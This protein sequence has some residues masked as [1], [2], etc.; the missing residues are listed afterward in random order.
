MGSNQDPKTIPNLINGLVDADPWVILTLTAEPETINNGDTSTITVDFNHINDGSA[1][2]GGHIPDG[3]LTLNIPWG[4]FQNP[5]ITHST[6]INTINSI[7]TTT[8]YANE[9]IAPSDPV[10]VTAT[11]DGYTTND[12]ESAHIT[13][14]KTADLVVTKTGPTTAI[15]GNQITYTIT[16]N[17]NGPDDAVNVQIQDNIPAVLQNVTQD[18][19]NLGTISAGQTKTV[20]ITGTIPLGTAVGT[21]IE[22][23]AT[24][25]SDTPGTI[26]P[27]DTVSTKVDFDRAFNP[28]TG[29]TFQTIQEAINDPDTINGDIILLTPGIYLENV[30][31]NKKLTLMP[32]TDMP[33]QVI[34][35]ARDPSKSVITVE[36]R[37]SGSTIQGLTLRGSTGDSGILLKNV[38]NCLITGNTLTGNKYGICAFFYSQLTLNKNNITQNT[39]GIYLLYSTAT[40]NQNTIQNNTKY[41]L[42]YTGIATINATNNWWG[43]TAPRYTTTFQPP[44]KTDIYDPYKKITYKPWLNTPPV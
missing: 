32:R 9:G 12:T 43:T 25:T 6:T 16:V 22:N 37:G 7:N 23:N 1:L 18:D 35:Q 27:S 3:P 14:T 41:G 36:N 19:F 4:S 20:T 15:A 31:L 29:E 42:E 40:I 11:A 8:F 21:N 30:L 44:T 38:Q 26:T 13:I 28:R 5:G 2:V 24:V 33:G 39:I 34:V 17:N 10:K